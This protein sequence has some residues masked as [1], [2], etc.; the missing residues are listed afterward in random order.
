MKKLDIIPKLLFAGY[1]IVLLSCGGGGDGDGG[2]GGGEPNPIPAPLATTLIFPDNNEECT[3]GEV[4]NPTQSRVVFE[5][6][7]SQNT[8]SYQVNVRNLNTGNNS[9]TSSTESSTPIILSEGSRTSGLWYH[10]PTEPTK[11]RPAQ[12]GA[13]T[14]RARESVIMPRF[15]PRPWR[16]PGGLH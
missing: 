4:I 1:T 7:D 14:M 16:P 11:Q 8:D 3:E 12:H 5:W 9:L 2:D 15:R 6:N 13:F 10:G